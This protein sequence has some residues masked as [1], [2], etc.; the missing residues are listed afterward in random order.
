[1]A[2]INN[3]PVKGIIM[4][5]YRKKPVVIEAIELT[6]DNVK[7][8]Y[9]FVHGPISLNNT[10]AQDKW[11]DYVDIV[12]RKGMQIKTLESD[13][14]HQI[15]DIGDFIIKGVE[16]EHYPCKPDIFWKTYDKV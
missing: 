13:N 8:V 6:L 12:R 16:G 10:I 2:I 4:N 5:R 15:S 7:E 9:E 14:Q 1:V 11:G 3:I